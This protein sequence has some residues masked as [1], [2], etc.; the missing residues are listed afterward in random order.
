MNRLVRLGLCG[1][2]AV[3]AGCMGIFGPGNPDPR[4]LS[5]EASYEWNATAEAYLDIRGG[6]YTAVYDL[7]NKTTGDAGTFEV[8]RRDAL[9]TE[10]PLPLEALQYRYPNGTRIVFQ[11]GEAVVLGPNGSTEPTTALAVSRT[12]HRTV[13]AIPDATGKIAFTAPKTGKE[14]ATPTFVDGAYEVV[15]PPHTSV[16]VPLLARVRPGGHTTTRGPDGR[17]H[18]HWDRMQ[19][20][21]VIVRYYLD[22]DLLIF[23]GLVALLIGA[24][25]AG[26]AY[27]LLQ[28]RQL[29]ERRR[30]VGLDVDIGDDDRRR[31]PPGMG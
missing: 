9:G 31:P 2:L 10:Q 27:Y 30:E 12:R 29:V 14:I 18:I 20:R 8:Y 15:L 1:F 11:E 6:S 25:V 28:I 7:S 22:R 21:T 19:A 13:I 4:S 16:A 5:A 3:T 26:A 23:G 17:M 24:G